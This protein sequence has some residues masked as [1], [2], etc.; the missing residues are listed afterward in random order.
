MTPTVTQH[1][2]PYRWYCPNKGGWILISGMTDDH[3]LK[4]I[5]MCLNRKGHIH[6]KL[7]SL[8]AEAYKRGL[9]LPRHKWVK[10]PVLPVLPV[11]PEVPQETPDYF[12]R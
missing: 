2:T 4:A 3:L 7:G 6:R 12:Y 9:P 10:I 11:L 8:V 5:N 1:S